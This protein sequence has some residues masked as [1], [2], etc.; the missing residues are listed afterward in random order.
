MRL[1]NRPAAGAASP[2]QELLNES[3][4]QLEIIG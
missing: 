1:K 3:K 4:K 2:V